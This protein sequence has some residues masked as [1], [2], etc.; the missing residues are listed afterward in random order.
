M[1]S[2]T[3]VPLVWLRWCMTHIAHH[4]FNLATLGLYLPLRIC[5]LHVMVHVVPGPQ[6]LQQLPHRL[7]LMSLDMK[8]D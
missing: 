4:I 7:A 5:Q 6:D 3:Q 1:R 2:T 8:S